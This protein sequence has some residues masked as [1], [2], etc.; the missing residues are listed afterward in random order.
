MS[1]LKANK[2][3]SLIKQKFKKIKNPFNFKICAF[4]NIIYGKVFGK[5]NEEYGEVH[6]LA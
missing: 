4:Q 2:A 3:R 1:K 5:K 6:V